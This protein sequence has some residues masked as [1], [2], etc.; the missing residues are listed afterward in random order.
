MQA[1]QIP[2]SQQREDSR[3]HTLDSRGLFKHC[4][5]NIVNHRAAEWALRSVGLLPQL[6][7]I[8]LCTPGAQAAMALRRR[9]GACEQTCIHKRFRAMVTS[10][11]SA[12]ASH[13][14]PM[15]HGCCGGCFKA[16]DTCLAII[17]C[18][19]WVC[20]RCG[21]LGDEGVGR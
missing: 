9:H 19:E 7:Q 17:G 20:L 14:G 8:G 3:P 1:L 16:D 11:S 4:E 15:R 18:R 6:L 10:C 21:G 5:Q 12:Q 2:L 13:R